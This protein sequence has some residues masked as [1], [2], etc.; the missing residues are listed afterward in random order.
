MTKGAQLDDGHTLD[1][2]RSEDDAQIRRLPLTGLDW[3]LARRQ[4]AYRP[5]MGAPR[6]GS[7]TMR[8]SSEATAPKAEAKA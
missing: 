4:A 7:T 2:H 6:V 1:P 8:A 5:S 3:S